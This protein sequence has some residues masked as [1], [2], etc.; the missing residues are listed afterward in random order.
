MNKRF[1]EIDLK[2]AFSSNG[3]WVALIGLA[4]IFFRAIR[5]NTNLETQVSTYEI[6][7]N[8]MALSGFT[9]F[10]AIFPVLGYSVSFCEEYHSGYSKMIISR[11]GWKPYTFVRTIS[12]A[13]SG[14]V[15]IGL[16]VF[17]VCLTGYIHGVHGVWEIYQ[18]TRMQYYIEQYGDWYI[19]VGKTILAFLFGALW[20]LVG[21][22]FAVWLCN[23]YAAL[24]AP[25]VL[26]EIMWLLLDRVNW[27]NPARLIR[28]DSLNNYP[29]SGVVQ[30]IY[31]IFTFVVIWCGMKRR[32]HYE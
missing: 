28:G 20:A 18:G 4:F 26:Y 19:L 10:A 15:I 3:F 14:G 29:L 23:R 27:L 11:I 16:P 13:L 32:C 12:T 22:A 24:I 9:P 25:F 31:I 1:L 21:M 5:V 6:I 7:A 8:A 30:I 2:R 17:L